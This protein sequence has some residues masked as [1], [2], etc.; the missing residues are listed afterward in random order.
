MK[1]LPR[2]I[3]VDQVERRPEPRGLFKIVG[4]CRLLLGMRC[5]RCGCEMVTRTVGLDLWRPVLCVGKARAVGVQ[6]LT[7]L[8]LKL[9][10]T[11]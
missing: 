5:C 10:K 2:I 1:I 7:V 4:T 8:G 3:Q 9:L 11:L 6:L